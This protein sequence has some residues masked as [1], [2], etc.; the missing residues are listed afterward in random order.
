MQRGLVGSE[1]CIRDRYQRRVHGA[2]TCQQGFYTSLEKLEKRDTAHKYK[3]AFRPTLLNLLFYLVIICAGYFSNLSATPDII[4]YRK[5]PFSFTDYPIIISQISIVAAL[6]IG[7][8]LNYLPLRE[9]ILGKLFGSTEY[10]CKRILICT[11]G[12]TVITCLLTI[13]LPNINTVLS[14]LG[15]IGCVTICFISPSVSYLSIRSN[16]KVSAISTVVVCSL[17]IAVG[18]GSAMM[19]VFRFIDNLQQI[20]FPCLL[21]TSDAADD[22]PCVDLGGRRIIKNKT[23]THPTTNALFIHHN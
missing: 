23:Q 20:Y 11:I 9:I 15:G 4:I 10:I 16:R 22:T 8:P 5:S 21:Y 12:F 3:V 7:I 18:I 1:M 13:L 19:A 2:F 6:C 17:L 14:I